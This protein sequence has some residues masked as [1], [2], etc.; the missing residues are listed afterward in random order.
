MLIYF[1]SSLPIHMTEVIEEVGLF[2]EISSTL[3]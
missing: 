1:N 3:P 2:V